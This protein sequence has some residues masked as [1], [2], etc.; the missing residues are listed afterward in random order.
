M[1][2][3]GSC[4]CEAVRFS[5]ESD[6][7]VPY[8]R[9]Y[10]SICRK[11]AG[12]AGSAINLGGDARTL[13]VKGRKFVK[14]YQVDAARTES[15]GTGKSPA[16][17]HFCTECG[18]ALWLFDPRWPELVH[19]FASAIDT[20]LPEAPAQVHM[21]QKY[22]DNWVPVPRGPNHERF[23]TYPALSLHD[24]HKKHGVLT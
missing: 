5:L 15:G 2:L 1:H 4:H 9:C 11:T 23:P 22:K 13:R 14:V 10:C 16:R 7:A 20:P 17:R 24:W 8:Q 21:M 3:E 6:T 18:S 19:P 12:G